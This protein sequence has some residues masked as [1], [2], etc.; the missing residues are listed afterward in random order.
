MSVR[1][2]GH[3]GFGAGLGTE[4]DRLLGGAGDPL[5]SVRRERGS[6]VRTRGISAGVQRGV[7]RSRREEPPRTDPTPR[8]ER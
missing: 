4:S 6:I 7:S 5:A 3:E 2:C 1:N 8:C